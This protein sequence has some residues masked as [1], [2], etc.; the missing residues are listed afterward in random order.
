MYK[1]LYG[2]K[3]AYSKFHVYELVLVYF[4]DHNTNKRVGSGTGL[5]I[6]IGKN[7]D[8]NFVYMVTLMPDMHKTTIVEEKL[9]DK[10][11]FH[12]DG[13]EDACPFCLETNCTKNEWEETA[14][15]VHCL[16]C[17]AMG[18]RMKNY[19]EAYS[20]WWAPAILMH[21]RHIKD[22]GEWTKLAELHRNTK[23]WSEQFNEKWGIKNV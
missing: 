16:N 8:N 21:L 7:A 19:S 10:Y 17:D 6:D 14:S 20:M 5:I 18:P 13:W 4:I 2:V 3:E 11:G 22:T 9:L 1:Q 15:Y 23:W 12:A